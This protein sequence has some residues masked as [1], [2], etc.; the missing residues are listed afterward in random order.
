MADDTTNE[1]G[2]YEMVLPFVA[3]ESKGGPFRDDDYTAGWEMGWLDQRLT[4]LAAALESFPAEVSAPYMVRTANLGQADL[5]A[6]RHGF[7][8]ETVQI[9]DEWASIQIKRG[10]NE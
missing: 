6:M 1:D 10:P 3:V 5:V 8:T 4:T 7:K 9:H 2:E